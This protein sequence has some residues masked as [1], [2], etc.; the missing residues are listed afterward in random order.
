LSSVE[1]EH[2]VLLETV[3]SVI[4]RVRDLDSLMVGLVSEVVFV[5]SGEVLSLI[6]SIIKVGF[7]LVSLLGTEL[8]VVK[9]TVVFIIEV[10]VGNG[11]ESRLIKFTPVGMMGV[12]EVSITEDV[13]VSKQIVLSLMSNFVT[14]PLSVRERNEVVMLTDVVAPGAVR[15]VVLNDN[16]VLGIGDL[17]EQVDEDISGLLASLQESTLAEL[18]R[19]VRES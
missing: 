11:G 9:T 14:I 7:G 17:A 4:D 10:I 12:E 6:I 19:E 8:D 2:E 16:E 5:L 13:V 15:S 3:L 1:V 18:L